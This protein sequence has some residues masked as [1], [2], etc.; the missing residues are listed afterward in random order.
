[1]S[2]YTSAETGGSVLGPASLNARSFTAWPAW[3]DLSLDIVQYGPDIGSESEL[4][5]LGSLD[6]KRV[7]EL[8]S[9]GGPNAVAMAKKGARVIAVDESEE[10]V[11]HSR[12]LAEREE[13]KVEF[14][15]G[16][17]AD[18]AFVRADTIDLALSVYSLGAVADL[19]RVFRQVHRVLRPEAPLVISLPHP[20]YRIVDG[21]GNPP[22]L[23][24]SY[25]DRT[26]IPWVVGAETGSDHPLTISD[27]FTSLGRANFRVDTVLEPEP[28]KGAPR[29][30]HWTEAM[31]WVP[32][33]LI[34]RAR[35]QGI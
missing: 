31:R 35:K 5:L 14:R 2:D 29:G 26:P 13:I 6:G 25:F 24:R 32:A 7:L 11:G 1:M 20:A 30:R 33:T 15:H 34:V 19:D 4:R 3:V 28:P 8:G 17:L 23:R 10:Q 18:L 16:D 21:N 27:L 12:R 9:G 22:S